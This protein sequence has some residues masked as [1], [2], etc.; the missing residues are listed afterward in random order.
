MT[1]FLSIALLI[2]LQMTVALILQ[3]CYT[4]KHVTGKPIEQAFVDKIRDGE[5]TSEQIIAWFGA[6]TTT[7]TL[8]EDMVY[9]YKHCQTKGATFVPSRFFGQTKTEEICDELTV[10]IDK[11]GKV[12]THN[13]IKRIQ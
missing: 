2:A 9:L 10:V 7:Y 8:G 5:T 4:A 11:T 1:N 13:F 6:P 3:S 12:K